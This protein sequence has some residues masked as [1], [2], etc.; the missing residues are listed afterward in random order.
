MAADSEDSSSCSSGPTVGAERDD[1]PWP[2]GDAGSFHA[3]AQRRLSTA[4][5]F[6]RSQR[7]RS[8]QGSADSAEPSTQT[9]V[10]NW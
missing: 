8:C 1:A 9:S 2:Y 3:N 5:A 6:L 7:V 10:V 4:T